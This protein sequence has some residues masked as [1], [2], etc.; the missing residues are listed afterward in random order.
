VTTHFNEAT[1]DYKIIVFFVPEFF[2]DHE[3]TN[4]TDYGNNDG[5]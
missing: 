1:R 5:I 3:G 4:E 2:E